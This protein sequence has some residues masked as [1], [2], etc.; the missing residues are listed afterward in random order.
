MDKH[1]MNE[2]NIIK[3]VMDEYNIKPKDI[4]N[5]DDPKH[6]TEIYVKD[7]MDPKEI[8]RRSKRYFRTKAVGHFRQ[9]DGCRHTHRHW[10][11]AHSWSV[12]DL[13]KQKFYGHYCQGCKICEQT[14][15]PFYR[16]SE[17]KRM[18]EWACRE[19]LIRIGK[20]ER[21][22]AAG[23]GGQTFGNSKGPHEQKLCGMCKKLGREC[24]K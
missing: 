20:L 23:S 22:F 12:I 18:A 1:K 8:D 15:T 19:Y 11:S 10:F 5:E 14:V 3:E 16:K 9:H 2:E 6:P 13:K 17:I 4:P 7:P 24:W 21:D